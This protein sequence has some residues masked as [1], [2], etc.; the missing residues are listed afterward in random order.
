MPKTLRPELTNRSPSRSQNELWVEH[1][2]THMVGL[3]RTVKA[4]KTELTLESRKQKAGWKSLSE[5]NKDTA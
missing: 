4:L 5:I 1:T 3:N 2:H